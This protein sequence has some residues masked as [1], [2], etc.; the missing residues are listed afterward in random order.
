MDSEITQ[1][2][3]RY[4]KGDR[5]ALDQLLPHVYRELRKLAG[6]QMRMEKSSH[7]L[8]PTALVHE[9]FMKLGNQ[10]TPWQNRS[11]FYGIAAQVMRR[12]LIDHARKKHAQKRG[13]GEG[14]LAFDEALHSFAKD[15]DVDILAVDDALTKLEAKDSYLAKLVE[16]KF[17]AG[18]TN[19]Q[20]AEALSVSEATVKRDWVKAKAWLYRA[21]KSQVNE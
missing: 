2:L 11:H 14:D 21:V 6:F 8:Q 7:T 10:N 18:F 16:L 15:K 19:E 13:A 20:I 17:F 1:L 9:A 4:Q 12:I 3:G 5:S